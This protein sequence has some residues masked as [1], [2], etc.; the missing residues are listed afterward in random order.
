MSLS[1]LVYGV[2]ISCVI[3]SALP[4][5]AES[6]PEPLYVNHGGAVMGLSP[7]KGGFLCI[8][9]PLTFGR[10][11]GTVGPFYG[12]GALVSF[13]KAK[14]QTFGASTDVQV[15]QH[16]G[17]YGQLTLSLSYELFIIQALENDTK[18]VTSAVSLFHLLQPS[19]HIGFFF[20]VGYS[21]Y[22][23]EYE[24]PNFGIGVQWLW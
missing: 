16:R 11:Q 15:H 13:G 18:Y 21:P 6:S 24:L 17:T 4:G 1:K 20:R 7:M 9:F 22:L 5:W 23:T 12:R 3:F 14:A 19:P 8:Y 2:I 10:L